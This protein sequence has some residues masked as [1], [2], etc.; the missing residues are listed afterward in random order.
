MS[1]KGEEEGPIKGTTMTNPTE[2]DD[3]GPPPT[4]TSPTIRTPLVPTYGMATSKKDVWKPDKPIMGGLKEI[5]EHEYMAWTGGEPNLEWTG[6]QDPDDTVKPLQFRALGSK[7]V[8]PQQTRIQGLKTK[9]D[10]GGELEQFCTNVYDH[11]KDSGMDTISYLP[12]PANPVKMISVVQNH[13]RFN[14]EYTIQQSNLF[15]AAWDSYDKANN[16]D[17][18]KFLMN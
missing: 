5:G 4:I 10:K 18:K 2:G 15:K 12:D 6:L 13:G 7:D 11:L 14:K 8:K 1:A 9:F 16:D 17:A 3:I